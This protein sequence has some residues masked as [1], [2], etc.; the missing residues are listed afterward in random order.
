MHTGIREKKIVINAAQCDMFGRWKPGDVL[1]EVQHVT[2]QHCDELGYGSDVL[3][4]MN[5][6]FVLAKLQMDVQRMPVHGEEVLLTTRAYQPR[7]LV[8][9]RVT[10]VSTPEGEVLVTVD[11]RWTLLDTASWRITRETVPGL[12]EMMLPMEEF[13]DIRMPNMEYQQTRDEVQV[14][15]AMLDINRH[16]NNAVYAD[17]VCNA[18]GEELAAGQQLKKLQLVYSREARMGQT[19]QLQYACEGGVHY[20]RGNHDGGQ[21]FAASAVLA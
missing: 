13:E 16:V 5:R 7:R 15:Y 1:R 6:A 8:Y 17:W 21:C 2:T 14:K 19:V 20:L 12:T 18:L 10:T 11:A 3:L 9:Q 4:A